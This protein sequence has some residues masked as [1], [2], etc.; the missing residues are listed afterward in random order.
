MS[1]REK[2]SFRY[3]GLNVVQTGKEVFVDQSSD[4]SSLKPAAYSKSFTK[5]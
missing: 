4:V 3:I 5:R 2:G 1:K